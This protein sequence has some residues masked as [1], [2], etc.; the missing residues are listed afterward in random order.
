MLPRQCSS[1]LI[2]EQ[3]FR[4]ERETDLDLCKY[5]STRLYPRLGSL[6]RCFQNKLNIFGTLSNAWRLCFLQILVLLLTIFRIVKR[7]LTVHPCTELSILTFRQKSHINIAT[8]RQ[9]VISFI[10]LSMGLFNS[11]CFHHCASSL[12]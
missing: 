1:E 4:Q 12:F 6:K 2:P 9:R 7:K 10:A 11:E 5:Q 8:Q 3:A